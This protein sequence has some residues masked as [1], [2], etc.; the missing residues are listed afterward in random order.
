MERY[1]F[2]IFCD[3]IRNEAG[4]K[5]SFMGCYN[6]VMFVPSR[7]P[8]V[9]PKFCIHL[10]VF[11]PPTQ[12]YSSVLARCYVPG[13]EAPF[14]EEPIDAPPA[15][16]QKKLLD[17]LKENPGSSRYIVVAASLILA[18]L[19]IREPGLISVSVVLDNSPYELR[20][21]ALRVLTKHS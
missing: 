19:E 12:P 14:A 20:L 15:H 9:L 4:G 21:G 18:P 3:D 5:L 10:H 13:Q 7:L 16:E 2:C 6:A 8:F 11:S 1:G 17:E